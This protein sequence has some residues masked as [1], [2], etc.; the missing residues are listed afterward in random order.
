[1]SEAAVRAMRHALTEERLQA[2]PVSLRFAH[3]RP[4]SARATVL[5]LPG[6]G[7]FIEKYA[8]TTNDL[9]ERGFATAHVEWRG[10]GLSDRLLRDPVPGHINDYAEYL[11][12][13]GAAVGRCM[14]LALP[15]PLLMLA[16]S[17][18][19]QIGLRFLHDAPGRFA[20]A[21]MT[22]PMWGIRL[23][24]LPMVLARAIA[25][26]AVRLGA[27]GRYAPGQA[28]W[29]IARCTFERNPLTSCPDRF[30]TYRALLERRPELAL[31]G[32]TYGWLAASL[33]SIALTRRPGYL[34]AIGTPVL[35][36]QSA[37]E[38]IVCNRSQGELVRR[39]PR[40][41]LE[42]FPEARHEILMEL[43][44][45]RAHFFRVLESFLAEAGA[46]LSRAE[47]AAAG[48]RERASATMEG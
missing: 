34:E 11:E 5:V 35:V 14:D 24:P 25:E 30:A 27:A 12:D 20:A 40:G 2:G 33:R 10:Q 48:M 22:A 36:C 43:P 17:M 6:R 26:A 29:D 21:V 47:R 39:L 1:M 19:G 37:L 3:A 45:V 7:E 46:L 44:A 38:R 8:E 31:G 4:R 32:V 18:G 42:I 15:R 13:L 28:A 9:L 41:R 23:G 16:H